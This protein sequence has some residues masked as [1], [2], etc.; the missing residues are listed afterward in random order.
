MVSR[1]S[2][3]LYLTFW[4]NIYSH[5]LQKKG[6]QGGNKT[7]K[8]LRNYQQLCKRLQK[9]KS[10]CKRFKKKIKQLLLQI[11][12]KVTKDSWTLILGFQMY[13]QRTI[14]NIL[15]KVFCR[16]LWYISTLYSKGQKLFLVGPPYTSVKAKSVYLLS[17]K[18]ERG[19]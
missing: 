13:I 9:V 5:L 19:M 7:G 6:R 18:L 3:P 16:I 11:S 4:F 10:S 8:N 2:S 17:G 14:A 12:V 15:L 1:I